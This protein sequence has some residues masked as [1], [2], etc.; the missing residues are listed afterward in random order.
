MLAQT[1]ANGILLGGLFGVAS[2]GFSLVWGVMGV[3]NLAHTAYLMVGSYI[4]YSLFAHFGVDPLLSMPISFIALFLLGFSI[5]FTL[6]N[7]LMERNLLLT[8]VLTF[9]IDLIIVNIVILIFTSD[10]V[11]VS[12]AYRGYSFEVGGAVIPVIRLVAFGM[13]LLLAAGCYLLLNYARLGQAI[14]ATALDA[15]IASTMGVNPR[16]IYAITAGLGAGFAG[17][18]G[19]LAAII[20]P[21]SPF[22]G[23]KFVGAAFVVTVLGGI[24]SVEGCILAGFLY[25]LIQAV[26]ASLFG[27]NTQELSAFLIFIL[28]L[29]VRPQGLLGKRFFGEH[30]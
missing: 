10:F 18:A 24:G 8:L 30:A 2:I 29:L 1:L 17:A 5:Q 3:I 26:S 14:M 23:A 13:A 4:A 27:V 19:N 7:R 6:L 16:L 22:M 25:G 15:E 11:A 12:P 9:G 20:F 28:V 21:I